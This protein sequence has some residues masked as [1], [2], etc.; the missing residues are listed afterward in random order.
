MAVKP[1]RGPTQMPLL[2]LSWLVATSVM[3]LAVGAGIG[4]VGR[5]LL[6]PCAG[7]LRRL[8][9]AGALAALVVHLAL[10]ASGVLRDGDMLDYAAVLVAA[11]VAATWAA[12][13]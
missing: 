8:A 12:R 5:L 13:G 6:R 10:V 7:S 3:P 11:V 2:L 1:D 4:A 9:L